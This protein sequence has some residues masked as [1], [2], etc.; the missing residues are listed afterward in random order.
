[1]LYKIYQVK[2]FIILGYKR[3]IWH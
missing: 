2:C 3:F 1:M